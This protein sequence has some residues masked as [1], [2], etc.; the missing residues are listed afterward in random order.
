MVIK[1][2]KIRMALYIV[3][4][5]LLIV[6]RFAGWLDDEQIKSLPATALLIG[7]S[8]GLILAALNAAPKSGS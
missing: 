4:V 7:T 8:A 3:L 6:A 1:N 5:V 2:P